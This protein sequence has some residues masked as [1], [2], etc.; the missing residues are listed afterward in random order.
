MTIYRED[1][2][3]DWLREFADYWKDAEGRI[4]E[5]NYI[6]EIQRAMGKRHSVEDLVGELRQRVG[7]DM[8]EEIKKESEKT[9]KKA[10]AKVPKYLEENPELHEKIKSIIRSEPF[11]S[12]EAIK[13]QL[14]YDGELNREDVREYVQELIDNTRP[15]DEENKAV[16]YNID[17]IDTEDNKWI[18][19]NSRDLVNKI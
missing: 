16:D 18:D 3:P 17:H 15:K 10:S 9:E 8:V 1:K 4:K 5:A 11:I 6:S 14:S 2:T 13:S 12:F 7:L 19:M